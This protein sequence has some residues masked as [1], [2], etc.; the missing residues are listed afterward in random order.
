MSFSYKDY[1]F[2]FFYLM[3]MS[4]IHLPFHFLYIFFLCNISVFLLF[5]FSFLLLFFS[6]SYVILASKSSKYIIQI[7]IFRVKE[8]QYYVFCYSYVFL[9]IYC[10]C[11][12]SNISIFLLILIHC[13]AELHETFIQNTT[14]FSH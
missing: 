1:L 10:L 7:S 3:F 14:P 12:L 4:V 13:V 5:L 9:V 6:F 8:G 2:Q 11:V